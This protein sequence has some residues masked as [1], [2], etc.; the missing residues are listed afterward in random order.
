LI[1]GDFQNSA[2][3]ISKGNLKQRHNRRNLI[4]RHHVSTKEDLLTQAFNSRANP[5]NR[6]QENFELNLKKKNLHELKSFGIQ[7]KE[8]I[9]KCVE[10][11]LSPR[12]LNKF[13]QFPFPIFQNKV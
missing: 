5:V 4:L 7:S 3:R 9:P 11:F 8:E 10:S 1:A 12:I 13:K 2:T 6:I